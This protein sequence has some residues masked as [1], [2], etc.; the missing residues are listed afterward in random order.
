MAS[1]D[2]APPDPPGLNDAIKQIAAEHGYDVG[3]IILGRR[4]SHLPV[5]AIKTGTTAAEGLSDQIVLRMLRSILHL[6]DG[7][8]SPQINEGIK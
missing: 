1:R 4:G 2:G 3:V 5:T 7:Q 6:K 8:L